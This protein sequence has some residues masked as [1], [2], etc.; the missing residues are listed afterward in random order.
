MFNIMT[1]TLTD[2]ASDGTSGD[3]PIASSSDSDLKSA[4]IEDPTDE[5]L[6]R[7]SDEDVGELGKT[8][9]GEF[10]SI[11]SFLAANST[12]TIVIPKKKTSPNKALKLPIIIYLT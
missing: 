8:D 2:G 5:T 12:E 3:S 1:Y 7:D 9:L 6:R 10:G 4:K 11:P